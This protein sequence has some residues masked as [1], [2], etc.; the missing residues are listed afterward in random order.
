ME[1]IRQQCWKGDHYTNKEFSLY[2]DINATVINST[3]ISVTL[4][5]RQVEDDGQ[6][7]IIFFYNFYPSQEQMLPVRKGL[8]VVKVREMTQKGLRKAQQMNG[9]QTFTVQCIKLYNIADFIQ[10]SPE[11]LFY[12]YYLAIPI[13]KYLTYNMKS[14]SLL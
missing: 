6:F 8:Q 7:E 11:S 12:F 5:S 14:I 9:I 4:N 2:F 13:F 10:Y 3:H 1:I